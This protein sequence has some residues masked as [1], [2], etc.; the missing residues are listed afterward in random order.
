[1]PKGEDI[2]LET[3]CRKCSATLNIAG[4]YCYPCEISILQDKLHRRNMQIKELKNALKIAEK[5]ILE[6][7]GK[8]TEGYSYK[9]LEVIRKQL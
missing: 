7:H 8:H 6:L 9:T 3:K 4:L 2:M 1:M 5:R